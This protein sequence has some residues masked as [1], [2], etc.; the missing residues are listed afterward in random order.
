MTLL[1][2]REDERTLK[3]NANPVR[4]GA[5]FVLYWMVATRRP[6]WNFALDR[7]VKWA[8][9]LRLPLLVLEALRVGYPWASDRFHRF[10]IDGMADT[11]R[12]L[13]RLNVGYYPYVEPQPGTGSG[14]L[15]ALADRAAVVVTDDY[16][17]FFLPRMVR[18]AAARVPVTFEAVD[19]NGLLPLHMA[20]RPFV[21]AFQF[22]RYLHEA[23]PGQLD[24]FPRERP[25]RGAG[26]PRPQAPPAHVVERW[27]PAD[28]SRLLAS[29]GTRALPI[30]HRIGPIPGIRGGTD[31]GRAALRR[32]VKERY[33]RYGADRNDPDA[34]ATSG[35]SAYLHFGQLSVHEILA[36]V[37]EHEGW[38]P[39]SIRE[40]CRG[41]R[42][43]WWG[44]SETG[45]SFLDEL[46]TWRELGYNT[47]TV[48]PG[49]D[50]FASLPGWARR[51]LAEHAADPRT[52]VYALADFEAAE[53]HDPLWNAAQR[54]LVAEGRIHGYLRMLWGK[55]I[56]EWSESPEAAF[57][58]MVELNNKYALD[59]R[60]PNSYSGIAWVMGRYD[61][62]WGPERAVFGK[63]RYMS[64]ENTA[65]K[66]RIRRYLERY[67][68]V[69]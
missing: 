27:P 15:E 7:A 16:P 1:M 44:L 24:V 22:R 12:A 67:G 50:Q 41:R 63:V 32:F 6:A 62:P 17:A 51:T 47:C 56:L 18:A 3:L 38:S 26:L 23:L 40:E 46:V 53:T 66:V 5:E 11:A 21:T 34:D 39:A 19:S 52:D 29:G 30:D 61:R 36:A 14:L 37:L 4:G 65:R 8:R 68:S 49:Y 43:G 33:E 25:V 28:I 45:E 59:G 42:Q 13:G 69:G 60:D 20:G 58:I 54:Q 35:L 10:V 48:D 64:S 55:K 9:E 31:A 2:K 57:D